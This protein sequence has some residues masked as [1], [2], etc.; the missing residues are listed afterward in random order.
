MFKKLTIVVLAAFFVAGCSSEEEESKGNGKSYEENVAA[1]ISNNDNIAGYGHVDVNRILTK[2]KLES[3]DMFKLVASDV[4]GKLKQEIDMKH[5]VYFAMESPES[6][7]TSTS[8]FFFKVKDAKKLKE[9]LR[10]QMGFSLKKTGEIDYVEDGDML[11]GIWG[12]VA[13]AVVTP[14]EFNGKKVIKKAFDR[15]NGK[16]KSEVTKTLKTTGDFVM[17]MDLARF[18]KNMPQSNDVPKSMLKGSKAQIVM[19]FDKSQLV[20]EARA[21]MSDALK[22]KLGLEKSAEP[23]LAKKLT[24]AAGNTLMAMQL[25]FDMSAMPGNP[26]DAEKVNKAMEDITAA[27]AFVGDGL[28][29]SEMG[30]GEKLLMPNTNKPI[31]GKM[32]EA[33]LDFDVMTEALNDPKYAMFLSRLDYAIY[34]VDGNTAKLVIKTHETNENFLV[35]VLNLAS[36]AYTAMMMGQLSI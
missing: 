29:I 26:F 22:K 17:N 1:F 12:D 9:D 19:N 7:G 20:I 33:Y 2:G 16:A 36:E 23:I 8:Y 30:A 24:D 6:R 28:N 14:G 27:L 13:I 10:T 35:T 32:F 31:G 15:T 34:E 5:P 3:N 25:S 18:V 11:L 4:Y 21:E